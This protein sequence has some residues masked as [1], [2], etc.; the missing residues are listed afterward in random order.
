MLRYHAEELIAAR[1]TDVVHP[2]EL[3]LAEVESTDPDDVEGSSIFA[4][5]LAASTEK[6][7]AEGWGSTGDSFALVPDEELDAANPNASRQVK[8]D[9]CAAPGSAGN[10]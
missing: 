1:P 7:P 3:T 9:E 10:C 8:S 2:K 5:Y 4:P 6:K